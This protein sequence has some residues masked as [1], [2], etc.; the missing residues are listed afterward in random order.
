M[1]RAKILVTAGNIGDST[2]DVLLKTGE[3]IRVAVRKPRSISAWDRAGVEQVEFDY[4]KP[5]TIKRAFEGVEKYFSVSPFVENLVE[6]GLIAIEHAKKAGVKL[7]VRS[8]ALGASEKAPIS[9][10]R[11]HGQVE[12]ALE[13]S[14]MNWAIVQP[15]SFMQNFFSYAGTIKSQGA[16]YVP[17]GNG[18]ASYVDCRDVGACAAVLLT[19]NEYSKQRFAVTGPESLSGEDIAKKISSAIQKNVR[20]V[21]VDEQTA[22]RSM[23]ESG[24]PD[25]ML[26]ALMEL[27]QITKAGFVSEVSG[28]G[29]ELI[30]SLRAFSDL[31]KESKETFL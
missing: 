15:A 8:S 31:A 30:G 18:Q 20:Y 7:F 23:K 5:D 21:D 11:W 3:K 29:K 14:G 6:T 1:D 19:K 27:N 12:S 26:K 13:K 17:L 2:I 24:V 25:W 16:F 22:I 28:D 10:G 4:A 9:M